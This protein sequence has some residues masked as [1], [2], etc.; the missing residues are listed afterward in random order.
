[1]A[2]DLNIRDIINIIE[3]K[4]EIIIYSGALAIFRLKHGEKEAINLPL[5]EWENPLSPLVSFMK[6]QLHGRTVILSGK[7]FS[8]E[9]IERYYVE[10][11]LDSYKISL[12]AKNEVAELSWDGRVIHIYSIL[13]TV[14]RKLRRILRL[15][16]TISNQFYLAKILKQSRKPELGVKY[17]VVSEYSFPCDSRHRLF[18]RTYPNLPKARQKYPN[19][20][21]Q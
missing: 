13:T 5:F 7:T 11:E 19:I 9:Q 12:R 15:Y 6:E 17:V 18:R 2:K 10:N 1:M 4:S 21:K 8:I 16:D 3:N 20:D 14:D